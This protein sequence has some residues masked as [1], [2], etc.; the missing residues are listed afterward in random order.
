M[1][2]KWYIIPAFLLLVACGRK[3]DKNVELEQKFGDFEAFYERFHRDSLFQMAHII[4]PLQGLPQRADSSVLVTGDFYWQQEDWIMH[5]D[6]NFQGSDFDRSFTP[7]GDNVLVEKI[8][9]K[10]GELGMIRR[11]ARMDGDWYL[12]YYVALNQ[13]SQKPDIEIQGGF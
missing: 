10:N 13:I 2:I 7:I 11:F 4:F 5:R 6:F 3:G 12:I 8:V 9:H 1:R